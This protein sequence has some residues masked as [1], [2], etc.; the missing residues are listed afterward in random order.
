MGLRH[1]QILMKCWRPKVG[2]LRALIPKK[3]VPGKDKTHP[4]PP[5][6]DTCGTP[7]QR[8][9]CPPILQGNWQTPGEILPIQVFLSTANHTVNVLHLGRPP[10]SSVV[11]DII[12]KSF[13]CWS[14]TSHVAESF[15]V[16]I[17]PSGRVVCAGFNKAEFTNT[18]WGS[19]PKF[20]YVS[21]H[22][23]VS[24]SVK[25]RNVQ[26]SPQPCWN[27]GLAL[28]EVLSD[29]E[30]YQTKSNF[31]SS[32]IA[33][34]LWARIL[35]H[36]YS[37]GKNRSIISAGEK[38]LVQGKQ[39]QWREST[40]LPTWKPAVAPSKSLSF[41]HSGWLLMN[42]ETWRNQIVSQ[43]RHVPHWGRLHKRLSWW[44]QSCLWICHMFG[45]AVSLV[46]LNA[47]FLWLTFRSEELLDRSL[48]QDLFTDLYDI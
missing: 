40:L 30:P 15:Q 33:I 13:E 1:T 21:L 47:I 26:T 48:S 16:E 28:G 37:N 4:C 32:F 8:W 19:S 36:A 29:L 44:H 7:S 23:A 11:G 41:R 14:D 46:L 45:S 10:A 17:H 39:G 43:S 34:H 22:G 24:H 27:S 12:P 20:C 6:A 9:W 18:G 35:L 3:S 42:F 38:C 25:G 5:S 31:K 2:I